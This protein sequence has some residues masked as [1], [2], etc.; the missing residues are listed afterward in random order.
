[1]PSHSFEYFGGNICLVLTLTSILTSHGIAITWAQ[2]TQYQCEVFRMLQRFNVKK[3][4]QIIVVN[5]FDKGLDTAWPC[6]KA[7]KSMYPD[8]LL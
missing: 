1:M 3:L 2:F 8:S 5:R 6:P 7:N 4:T